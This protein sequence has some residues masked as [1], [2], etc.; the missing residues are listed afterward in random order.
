MKYQ[1]SFTERAKKDIEHTSPS[2]YPRLLR[3]FELISE[4]P[5]V[6]KT[7]KGNLRG[8]YS[9]RVG[10]HRIIYEILREKILVIILKIG[11]RKE[12]YR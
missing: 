6:G 3:A 2:F 4:N 1:L 8:Q 7:L 10:D 9:Y 12:I 11:H 5:H